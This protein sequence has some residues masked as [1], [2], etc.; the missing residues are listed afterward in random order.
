MIEMGSDLNHYLL[1][2]MRAMNRAKID[3]AAPELAGYFLTPKGEQER[4]EKTYRQRKH[5]ATGDSKQT[6][7]W[8]SATGEEKIS[9]PKKWQGHSRYDM[10]VLLV[11]VVMLSK[12]DKQRNQPLVLRK[13]A[14]SLRR[15]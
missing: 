7:D 12:H 13:Q 8:K 4:G 11:M 15:G 10:N 1:D 9:R 2:W 6:L 5:S 14:L 3:K